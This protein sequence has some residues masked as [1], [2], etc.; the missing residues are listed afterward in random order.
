MLG[1]ERILLCKPFPPRE[2]LDANVNVG[3]G[4]DIAGGYSADLGNSMRQAVVGSRMR[5]GSRVEVE[6]QSASRGKE[7][8]IS[9]NWMDALYLATKGGADALCLPSGSGT[10]TIGAPFDAQLS[11]L[12]IAI[13]CLISHRNK[14]R[15]TPKM[16]A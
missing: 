15:R 10:F 7:G 14:S 5:E 16:V 8:N 2:A 3:L 1:I 6:A 12:I 11:K 4:T 13:C 9:V